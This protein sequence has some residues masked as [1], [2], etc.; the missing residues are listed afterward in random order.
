MVGVEEGVVRLQNE[1]G[2]LLVRAVLTLGLLDALGPL[3]VDLYVPAFPELQRDLGLGDLAAQGT[4]VGM[5]AGLALGQATVG[6]WSDRVGR[7]RPLLTAT[8]LHVAASVGCAVAPSVT[9]LLACRVLQGVG[10]AGSAVLVL[11]IV[12]D[13]TT[14][15]A[16]TAAITRVALITTVTPLAAPPLGA[17]L[18]PTVGWRGLFSVLGVVGVVALVATASVIPDTRPLDPGARPNRLAAVLRDRRFVA[19][20]IVGAATYAGVYAYVAA[21]PLL[22]RGSLGLTATQYA[23]VYLIGSLGLV[24]VLQLAGALATRLPPSRVLAVCAAVAAA[25]ALALLPAQAFGLPG[26]LPCLWVF[27]AASGGCFPCAETLALQRQAA[28]AG[29][30]TSVYGFTTFAAAAVVPAVPGLLGR[31]DGTSTALVLAGT[32]VVTLLVVGMVLGRRTAT[33]SPA[34]EGSTGR[35]REG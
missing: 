21:S 25:A 33:S 12:R 6:A 5:T 19:A 23:L 13:V 35:D 18:L 29:T 17:L 30:A 20:T 28:Q 22:L 14:G 10:A 26:V 4:L 31:V 27:V 7:R 1:Q 24:G 9:A 3:S 11:A 2:R 15:P 8:A 32:A 34:T 16:F